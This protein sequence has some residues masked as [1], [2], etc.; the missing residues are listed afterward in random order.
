MRV[1]ENLSPLWQNAVVFLWA[2]G[3]GLT[4]VAALSTLWGWHV[5]GWVSSCVL[6]A[7]AVDERKGVR[8]AFAVGTRPSDRLFA[9]YILALASAATIVNSA[10]AVAWFVAN[11]R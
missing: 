8:A 6:V 5:V 10:L 2:L 1:G 9:L 4:F 11:L 7:C 3:Y